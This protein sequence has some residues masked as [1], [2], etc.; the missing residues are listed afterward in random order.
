MLELKKLPKP[1]YVNELFLHNEH[2]INF[3]SRLNEKKEPG[4]LF[5]LGSHQIIYQAHDAAGYKSRCT[6]KVVVNA[7]RREGLKLPIENKNK[8]YI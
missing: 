1:M 4:S 7:P 5:G 3:C 2:L 8:F 6:F